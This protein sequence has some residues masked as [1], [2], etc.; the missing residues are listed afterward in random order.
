[1]AKATS[2]TLPDLD[3]DEFAA[4]TFLRGPAPR[5]LDQNLAHGLRR[6]ALKVQPRLRGKGRPLR[7]LQP[8]L[9]Y[10]SG[11]AQRRPRVNA[12]HCGSQTP[13]FLVSN[14]EQSIER[15][16]LV[17]SLPPHSRIAGNS[18]CQNFSKPH[19]GFSL[20]FP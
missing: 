14:T 1:M 15:L 18:R 8:R 2:A 3:D 7:Q 19:D 17:R 16:P 5:R 12:L 4:A 20:E 9:V 10:Q 6:N 13:Q 11:G